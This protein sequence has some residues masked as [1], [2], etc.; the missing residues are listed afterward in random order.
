M[1]YV[2]QHPDNTFLEKKDAWSTV[3][4]DNLDKARVFPTIG[5]TTRAIRTMNTGY[6]NPVEIADITVQKIKIVLA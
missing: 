6:N 1:S 4:T 5:A 2:I 3:W